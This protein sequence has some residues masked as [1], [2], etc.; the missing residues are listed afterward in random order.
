MTTKQKLA[1]ALTTALAPT[2][3]IEKALSG[4]YD[5]FESDSATPIMDLVND[6]TKSGFESPAMTKLAD[7][8]KQGRFDATKEES[9]AWWAKNAD[10]FLQ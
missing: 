9:D 3:M 10:E 1:N 5:D 7:D 2:W 8:A 4:G 6:L